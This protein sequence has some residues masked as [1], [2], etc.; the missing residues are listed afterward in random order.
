MQEIT[1]KNFIENL[2]KKPFD[3]VPKKEILDCYREIFCFGLHKS[4]LN[5]DGS[6]LEELKQIVNKWAVLIQYG[7]RSKLVYIKR[8]NVTAL[9]MTA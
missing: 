9:K 2:Y 3:Q 1:F 8:Q 7:T 6:D 5:D 4:D